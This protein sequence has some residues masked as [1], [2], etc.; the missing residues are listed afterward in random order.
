M[1]AMPAYINALEGG[2]FMK[3][4]SGCERLKATFVA[5]PK[6]HLG[7]GSVCKQCDKTPKTPACSAMAITS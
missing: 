7:I 3:K 6:G 2:G 4:C 5:D 1:R